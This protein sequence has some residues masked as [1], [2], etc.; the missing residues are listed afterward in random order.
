M[1]LHTVRDGAASEDGAVFLRIHLA[2]H[3]CVALDLSVAGFKLVAMCNC[4]ITE[5]S[6]RPAV[7]ITA[8]K[9]VFAYFLLHICL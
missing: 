4:L 6:C 1:K 9:Q 2:K 7:R 3:A 5:D 8:R